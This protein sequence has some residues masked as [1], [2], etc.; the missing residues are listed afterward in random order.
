MLSNFLPPVIVAVKLSGPSDPAR[1]TNLRNT[2]S[3]CLYGSS[4]R[5]ILFQI[6]V[7]DQCRNQ[8]PVLFQRR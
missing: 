7:R 8:S 5:R 6:L 2:C 1:K 4:L 3:E